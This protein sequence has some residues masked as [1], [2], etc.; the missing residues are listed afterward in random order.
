MFDIDLFVFAQDRHAVASLWLQLLALKIGHA[1]TAQSLS[2]MRWCEGC[3]ARRQPLPVGPLVA[4]CAESD[5]SCATCQPPSRG[6]MMVKAKARFSPPSLGRTKFTSISV[7]P[8]V[9]GTPAAKLRWP[10]SIHNKVGSL[11]RGQ[12][13]LVPGS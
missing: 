3:A 11:W 12:Q 6:W 2:S 5:A 7:L 13:W 4:C 9:S 8:C 10:Y 1:A